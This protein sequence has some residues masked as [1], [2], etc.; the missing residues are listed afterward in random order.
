MIAVYPRLN[1]LG[2]SRSAG[3]FAVIVIFTVISTVSIILRLVA[4]RLSKQKLAVEDYTILIA[5]VRFTLK[6]VHK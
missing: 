6:S 2:A 4:K 5:Q 1:E 3:T